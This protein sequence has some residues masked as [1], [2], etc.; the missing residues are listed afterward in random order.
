MRLAFYFRDQWRG[1]W[2]GGDLEEHCS[3]GK[4]PCD[5]GEQERAGERQYFIYKLSVEREL[6]FGLD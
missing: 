4:R 5:D 1:E 3:G 2:F 6:I